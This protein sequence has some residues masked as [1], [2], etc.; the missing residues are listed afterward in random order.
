MNLDQ[1]TFIVTGAGS[2]LG[3]GTAD[4]FAS[5]GANVIL[6]DIN[7]KGGEDRS[8]RL[9]DT[10]LFCRADVA[11]EGDVQAAISAGI[12]R[13]GSVHGAINCAGIVL[14]RKTLS[15]RGVHDLASFERVIRVN[16][17]GSFNVTRLAAEAMA[18]NEPNDEGER[19]VIISTASVAAYEGQIGQA[20]YAASKGGIVG[21][22]LPVAR[23]LSRIG[24]RVMAI[25]P[26]IFGTPMVSGMPQ[27][28]QD[29]LAAQIPFPSRLGRPAEYASLARHIVEN[30]ML[31]GEVIRLDGAIRMGPK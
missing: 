19:G 7:E 13:F 30:P 20:A 18:S 23:D 10:A 6:L 4:L 29:S 8:K 11:D 31:N 9:G 21:M 2:G 24:I 14:G 15:S 17:M 5:H 16:L 22:T 3:G 28:V 25:A 12:D 1:H 27:D 26:G